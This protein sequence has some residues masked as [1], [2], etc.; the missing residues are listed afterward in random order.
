MREGRTEDREAVREDWFV[1]R[2]M[3]LVC[4]CVFS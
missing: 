2:L 1:V 4:L 3:M